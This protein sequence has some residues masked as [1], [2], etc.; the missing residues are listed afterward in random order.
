MNRTL[1]GVLACGLLLSGAHAQTNWPGFGNDPGADRFSPLTQIDTKN[2]DKLTLA[3]KFDTT[4]AN[5][6]PAP[7]SPIQHDGAAPPAAYRIIFLE[8]GNKYV[9]RY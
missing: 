1:L 2:V 6:A 9:R 5:P 4:V 8:G 3:W 7:V